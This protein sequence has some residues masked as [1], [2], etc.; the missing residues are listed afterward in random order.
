MA[1][2]RLS[3]TLC[4]VLAVVCGYDPNPESGTLKCGPSNSCPDGFSCTQLVNSIGA[5]NE[6]LTGAYCIKTGTAY[7][8]NNACASSCEPSTSPCP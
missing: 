3:A 1:G 5:A 4:L 2:A 8:R 7:D 6:G